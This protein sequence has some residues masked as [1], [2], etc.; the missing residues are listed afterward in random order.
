MAPSD[1]FNGLLGSRIVRALLL[2][3]ILLVGA[4]LSFLIFSRGVRVQ[5]SPRPGETRSEPVPAG[6]GSSELLSGREL[7]S[8]TSEA[9]AVPDEVTASVPEVQEP[10]VDRRPRTTRNEALEALWGVCVQETDGAARRACLREQLADLTLTPEELAELVCGEV[11]PDGFDQIFVEEV[12]A[13]WAPIDVPHRIRRFQAGCND[14][15]NFWTGFLEL[16]AE[17]DP[18]WLE[19]FATAL[20]EENLFADEGLVLLFCVDTLAELGDETMALTM[21]QCARGELHGADAQVAFAISNAYALRPNAKEGLDFLLGV[22]QSPNF[23]GRPAEVKALARSLLEG[24]PRE[25]DPER[26]LSVVRSLLADPLLAPEIAGHVLDLALWNR[27]PLWLTP[28]QRDALV[29]Q[30][31]KAR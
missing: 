22:A 30:A 21:D 4:T 10:E 3:G 24:S 8:R 20:L 11:P 26:T 15:G 5:E 6:G 1:F 28:S 2:V 12:A 29:E 16:Q 18:I 13:S 9:A 27:L 14:P 19:G 23:Q 17:R 31:E 25:F 7:E